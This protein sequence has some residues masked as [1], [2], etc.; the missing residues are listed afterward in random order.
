MIHQLNL[1]GTKDRQVV[2]LFRL[3]PLLLEGTKTREELEAY[4]VEGL[5]DSTSTL[6]RDIAMIKALGLLEFESSRPYQTRPTPA[7][8]LWLD[9]AESQAVEVARVLLEQL[10]LPESQT[11]ER[12]IERIPANIRWKTQRLPLMMAPSL[13]NLDPVI[14]DALIE[15]IAKGRKL[16][17]RY[18][19]PDCPEPYEVVV[20]R[21]RL[22]WMT[23]AFY[24]CAYRPDYAVTLPDAPMYEHVREYRVDRILTAEVL[25]EIVELSELPMISCRILL[26]A[27]LKGRLSDMRDG[28][29]RLVQ[30]V[31]A[32]R[33]GEIEVRFEEV[34][35]LR[36]RQRVLMFGAHLLAVE[37][38]LELRDV[39]A[40]MVQ[41]LAARF[42]PAAHDSPA[43]N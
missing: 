39:V 19:R 37:E 35:L 15:G 6:N 10:G 33:N 5:S 42:P 1:K 8:P 7:L 28:Q 14:W 24:L 17:L 16:R 3:L 9:P 2:R 13:R 32:H 25:P 11:I 12:F 36:A 43:K 41:K 38:P 23:N 40:A 26:D 31:K 29:G 22:S 27:D 4:L 30:Q 21:A 18:Q 20:D 34:S